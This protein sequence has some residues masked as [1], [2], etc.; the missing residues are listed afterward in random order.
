MMCRWGTQLPAIL[1]ILS[2]SLADLLIECFFPEN[3]NTQRRGLLWRHPKE[4]KLTWWNESSYLLSIQREVRLV[5]DREGLHRLFLHFRKLGCR[6]VGKIVE[7][8]FFSLD[9]WV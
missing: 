2:H 4:G 9:D 3:G 5:L 6:R 8:A 7:P 1:S